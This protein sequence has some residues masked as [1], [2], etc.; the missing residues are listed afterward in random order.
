MNKF[1]LSTALVLVASGAMAA[2]LPRRTMAP[3]PY[4]PVAPVFT[5][6]GPYIGAQIG[7]GWAGDNDFFLN[8]RDRFDFGDFNGVSGEPRVAQSRASLAV[9]MLATTG[10]LAALSGASRAISKRQALRA[11]GQRAA[12]LASRVSPI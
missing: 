6:T 7:Y 10:R 2:D 12:P 4:V 1:L 9:S 3:A 11:T 8:N 5:W